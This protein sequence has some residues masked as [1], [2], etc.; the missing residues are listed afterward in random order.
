MFRAAPRD[1]PEYL[2]VHRV[3]ERVVNKL[4]NQTLDSLRRKYLQCL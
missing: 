3:I 2:Q 1:F 4:E